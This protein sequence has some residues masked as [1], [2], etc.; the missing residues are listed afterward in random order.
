MNRAVAHVSRLLLVVAVSLGGFAAWAGGLEAP[1]APTSPT[2]AM[3]TTADVYNRLTT[4]AGGSKRA[5]GFAE[6]G[7]GPTAGIVLP[8]G[9]T[10]RGDRWYDPNNGTIIDTTTGL[11]WFKDVSVVNSPTAFGTSSGKRAFVATDGANIDAFRL[12]A[13]LESGV[14]TFDPGIG[15]PLSGSSSYGDWRIPTRAEMRSLIT[16]TGGLTSGNIS[17][18]GFTNAYMSEYYWT[19]TPFEFPTDTP[20]ASNMTTF[21]P[22]DGQVVAAAKAPISYHCVWPVRSH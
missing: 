6:P 2:S 1:A 5:G 17:G 13:A 18:M 10:L 14:L 20:H 21:C 16:G 8:A 11:V 4:G 7:S 19:A 15:A 9:G 12:T 22:A 3:F